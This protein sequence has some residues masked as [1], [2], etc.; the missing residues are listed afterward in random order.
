METMLRKIKEE[1]SRVAEYTIAPSSLD[2]AEAITTRC[3][4]LEKKV[5]TSL[6]LVLHVLRRLP[7]DQKQTFRLDRQKTRSD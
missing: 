2:N 4:G 6:K 1:L 5:A 3:E 7:P